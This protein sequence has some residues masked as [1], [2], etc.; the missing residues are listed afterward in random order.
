MTALST[1]DTGS[2]TWCGCQTYTE[3]LRCTGAS[4]PDANRE[5]QIVQARM[6]SLRRAASVVPIPYSGE[7]V[8]L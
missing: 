3:T 2:E 4:G 6:V 5:N 1:C 7:N 8:R